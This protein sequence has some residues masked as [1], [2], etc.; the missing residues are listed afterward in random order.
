MFRGR[1][2]EE[3][4]EGPGERAPVLVFERENGRVRNKVLLIRTDPDVVRLLVD[5]RVDF[6]PVQR[7]ISL[8]REAPAPPESR[9]T[10]EAAPGPAPR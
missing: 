9:A 6:R 8:R 10:R 3:R 1:V 2:P 7:V 4:P 5:L